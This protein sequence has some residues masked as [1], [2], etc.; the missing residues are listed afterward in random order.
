[1]RFITFALLS[2]FFPL[3]AFARGMIVTQVIDSSAAARA[4]FQPRD[5]VLSIDGRSVPTQEA[6]EAI[7]GNRPQPT[8]LTIEYQRAGQKSTVR[9]AYPSFDE[10]GFGLRGI[11]DMPI[12]LALRTEA[13]TS[14]PQFAKLAETANAAGNTFVAGWLYL[15]AADWHDADSAEDVKKGLSLI[16]TEDDPALRTLGLTIQLGA[17][18]NPSIENMREVAKTLEAGSYSIYESDVLVSLGD[19]EYIAHQFDASMADYVRARDLLEKERPKSDRL[20]S[21]YHQVGL[22]ATMIGKFS[23]AEDMDMKAVAIYETIQPDSVALATSYANAALAA[24]QRGDAQTGVYRLDKAVAILKK[25]PENSDVLAVVYNNLALCYQLGGDPGRAETTY[26]TCIGM[27]ETLIPDSSVQ[28]LT[29]SNLALLLLTSGKTSEASTYAAAG[30]TVA[31]A[32]NPN[33]LQE[34]SARDVVG[35]ID[36]FANKL[37]EAGLNFNRCELIYRQLAPGSVPEALALS[38]E[39]ALAARHKDFDRARDLYAQ[40]VS[41][42]DENRK[43]IVSPD[44][45]VLLQETTYMVP[46][47]YS[48]ALAL[49]EDLSGAFLAIETSRGRGLEDLMAEKS[50]DFAKGAPQDLLLRDKTNS[51]ALSGTKEQ[52]T[53]VEDSIRDAEAHQD[54]SGTAALGA[55]LSA[56]R[57]R[58]ADERASQR[59]LEREIRTV[60]PTFAALKYPEP[61]TLQ[62]LDET[63]APGDLVVAFNVMADQTQI[64]TCQ[65]GAKLTFEVSTVPMP[66]SQ[67]QNLSLEFRQSIINQSSS[68]KAGDEL[69]QALIKP[70]ASQIANC[71]HLLLM[72]DRGLNELPFA[73]LPVDRSKTLG[74]EVPITYQ[75]SMSVYRDLL[76]M[77]TAKDGFLG[78]AFPTVGSEGGSEFR[79]GA[80]RALPNAGKE[81]KGAAALF[82]ESHVM[83]NSSATL[84]A[85][86]PK[87]SDVRYIHF[88]CHGILNSVSPLDSGLALC[89]HGKSNGLLLARDFLKMKIKADLVTLSSCDSGL[90]KETYSEGLTGFARSLYYAGSRSVLVSLWPV[91]DES[92]AAFMVDFYSKLKSGVTK[93]VA[94]KAAI[95]LVKAN[96]QFSSPKFWAPFVLCGAYN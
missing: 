29:N 66:F 4:G 48:Q 80:I 8:D 36:L 56:L 24:G 40:A 20:A 31:L 93:D 53:T 3:T 51:E 43:S 77:Q 32:K 89:P 79:G 85:V 58:A 13:A 35:M 6:L 64:L 52:I 10:P 91:E 38:N 75:T 71:K 95:A 19:S 17:S 57:S 59:D 46:R 26:K 94:L 28:G 18:P 96:P 15:H 82:K 16:S 68:S 27:E 41:I 21:A 30:L 72:P 62:E 65:K 78:I 88:A 14:A 12:E 83:L 7:I 92:T 11:P 45:R 63:L 54:S 87:L 61:L 1:M 2:L 74:D 5:L 86:V 90:G 81:V 55:S 33:S 9:V 49:G 50:V 47:L 60:S 23:L 42:V 37:D 69:Y 73:A 22:V 70:I 34:A 84:T 25:H 44:E 76:S 67:L 39:G